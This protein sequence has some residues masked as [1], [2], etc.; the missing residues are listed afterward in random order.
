MTLKFEAQKVAPFNGNTAM[1][2]RWKRRTQCTFYGSGYKE[3]LTDTHYAKNHLK[4]NKLVLSQ[5]A[6]ATV[7][8]FVSQ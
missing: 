4:R 8:A 7:D 3:I 5:S 6:L 2:P 1:W